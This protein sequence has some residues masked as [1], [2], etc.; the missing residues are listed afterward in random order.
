[1]GRGFWNRTPVV[2]PGADVSGCEYV[3]PCR[4]GW[5]PNAYY[6]V[7]DGRIVHASSISHVPS[8]PVVGS[9]QSKIEN[10]TTENERLGAKVREL[11]ERLGSR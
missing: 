10:L 6:R 4:C 3:G 9:D 2:R 7:E 5:G 1:M 11:E 8:E